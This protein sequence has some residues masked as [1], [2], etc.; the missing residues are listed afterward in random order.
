MN[1]D[2]TV[3][4]NDPNVINMINLRRK[5]DLVIKNNGDLKDGSYNLLQKMDVLKYR[6]YYKLAF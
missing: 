1:A 4:R 3:R 5:R 2:I 6:K